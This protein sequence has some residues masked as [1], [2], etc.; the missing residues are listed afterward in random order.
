MQL[1]ALAALQTA[2]KLAEDQPPGPGL[3]LPLAGGVYTRADLA[4][5]ELELLQEPGYNL[6]DITTIHCQ[7]F[8]FLWKK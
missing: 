8:F 5:V 2:A 4:R 1:L 6:T 3:L 7:S